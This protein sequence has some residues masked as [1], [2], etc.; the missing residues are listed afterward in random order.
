ML[1]RAPNPRNLSANQRPS[2][3]SKAEPVGR[4]IEFLPGR[5]LRNFIESF[6]GEFLEVNADRGTIGKD[7]ALSRAKETIRT[8]N[9]EIRVTDQQHMGGQPNIDLLK[10]AKQSA[11]EAA[12]PEIRQAMIVVN[13]SRDFLQIP[14]QQGNQRRP[15]L[16][17]AKDSGRRF[18]EFAPVGGKATI[19]NQRV[20]GQIGID[21][22]RRHG[23]LPDHRLMFVLILEPKLGFDALSVQEFDHWH[24]K[25]ARADREMD[26]MDDRHHCESFNLAWTALSA[27][28]ETSE[29]P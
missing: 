13:A 10:G 24:H 3:V 25:I 18:P 7:R 21:V 12:I 29:F 16:M 22:A 15:S 28:L 27:S 2:D 4:Q 19:E 26:G 5:L 11:H 1:N 23:D 6:L 20:E 17:G 9:R 8:R 14:G